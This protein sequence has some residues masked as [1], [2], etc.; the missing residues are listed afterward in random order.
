MSGPI[1]TLLVDDEPLVLTSLR[2]LLRREDF[3]VSLC[4]SGAEGLAH[5]EAH[6]ADLV[7]SDYMMPG[8]NGLAFLEQ[9][10]AR[11]PRP[12]RVLLT[13]QADQTL[14]E[15]ALGSGLLHLALRKPWE[16]GALIAALRQVV[17]AVQPT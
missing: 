8:M 9:V 2:R 17:R 5:L 12:A 7:V 11:W 1:R 10:R 6:A 4:A 15:R 16:N 3:E 13:A 14:V